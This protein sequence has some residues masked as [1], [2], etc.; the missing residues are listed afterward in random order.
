MSTTPGCNKPSVVITSACGSGDNSYLTDSSGGFKKENLFP[1]I[2][3]E[4]SF[5][6]FVS[7]K[8]KG[9]LS[10]CN[11]PN[12]HLMSSPDL[13]LKPLCRQFRPV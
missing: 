3:D 9:I 11:T 4:M 8:E 5:K 12:R 1:C 13:E 10:S 6:S 7:G 2:D